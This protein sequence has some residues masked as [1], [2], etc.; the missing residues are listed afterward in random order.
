MRTAPVEHRVERRSH[1][2]QPPARG[3]DQPRSHAVSCGQEAVLARTSA[4]GAGCGE[5]P[6]S[7]RR[8]SDWISATRGPP[9]RASTGRPSAGPRRS[10]A[11]AEVGRPTRRSSDRVRLRRR[12]PGRARP[13]SR[14]SRRRAAVA[15]CAGRPGRR[16]SSPFQRAHGGQAS[17]SATDC[18][19]VGLCVACTASSRDVSSATLRRSS[20]TFWRSLT[21]SAARPRS[22]DPSRWARDSPSAPPRSGSLGVT[23]GL[24]R[25]PGFRESGA[26]GGWPV[27]GRR[28]PGP[29]ARA[30]RAATIRQ[31]GSKGDVRG[32]SG[33]PA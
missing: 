29:R 18:A 31:A 22:A 10:R 1:R 15:R 19:S 27:G 16:S 11:W 12:S 25:A 9:L 20:A 28:V 2:D 32:R 3:L 24:A 6:S 26:A 14:R 7:S 23:R 13:R 21:R 17:S 30:R 33:R 5:S 8:E 4:F